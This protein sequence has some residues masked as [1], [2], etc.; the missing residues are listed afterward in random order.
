M[1]QT[2]YSKG[3]FETVYR[4]EDMT[5]FETMSERPALR[6]W[7]WGYSSEQLAEEEV[8]LLDAMVSGLIPDG[9]V[10]I[11]PPQMEEFDLRPPR[12]AVPDLF[13]NYFSTIPY[14]LLVH[15]Y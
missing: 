15:C 7:G 14:D 4:N 8:A 12:I 9:G 10:Q 2:Y 11:S 13:Q 5:Q 6:F 1:V 3:H